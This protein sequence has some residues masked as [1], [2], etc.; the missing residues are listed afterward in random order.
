MKTTLT[1]E[2]KHIFIHIPKT[3]GTTLQQVVE[4]QYAPE[5]FCHLPAP[6]KA[7]ELTQMER[8]AQMSEEY[9]K[10]VKA[11]MGHIYPNIRK[12]FGQE[13]PC[14]F[15]TF[16]RD[17]V[18]KC[19]SSYS[20]ILNSEYEIHQ[21]TLNEYD[22]LEKYA[23]KTK[24]I[25]T[26]WLGLSGQWQKL[27]PIKD[28]ERILE[29]A[30]KAIDTKYICGVTEYFDASLQLLKEVLGWQSDL[31]YER[32]N[33]SKSKS[34]KVTASSEERDYIRI[35]NNLDYKLYEYV[36]D[37]FKKELTSRGINY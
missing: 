21:R 32:K 13:T 18:E 5:K 35:I 2:E 15:I 36:L 37:K 30:Y 3:A 9:R 14:V 6:T 17:P 33:E 8:F 7:L 20:Q 24:N 19:I 25:Q 34:I 27:D 31:S 22:T 28:E 12:N 1:G 16:L 4:R 10:N 11:I 29:S 26:R 23:D